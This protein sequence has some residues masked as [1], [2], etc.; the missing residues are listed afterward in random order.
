MNS[1]LT[2][3]LKS[4]LMLGMGV[5]ING[6][7][8]DQETPLDPIPLEPIPQ[9]E[10]AC[11]G[12]ETD[13]VGPCCVD[14]YCTETAQD[15]ICL[16]A[17]ETYAEEVTGL[18]LGSGQ[19]QCAEVAGPYAAPEGQE[20]GPCCYLVGVNSCSGRPM[21]AAGATVRATALK[22]RRWFG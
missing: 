10:V 14:V 8:V 9:D 22:G 19:C 2:K 3:A 17:E 16:A 15:G 21:F 12:E 7:S 6:C 4:A 11:T 5:T 18:F 13:F 20:G 1:K